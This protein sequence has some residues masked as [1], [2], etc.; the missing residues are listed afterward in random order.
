LSLSGLVNEACDEDFDPVLTPAQTYQKLLRN[1]TEKIRFSDM[2]GRIAAVMLVPYPPGIP[3]SM[4]GERLGGPDS[5]VIKLILAME[6]FS[7]RFPG[8][9]REVHGIEVDA[10]GNYWMRS[11][12]EAQ[13]KRRNGNGKNRPPS[14]A[15]PVKKRRRATVPPLT[16]PPHGTN[17]ER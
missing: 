7:K 3:M 12:I 2:A 14:S 17:T 1:E 10:E 15:P 4:P 16:E 6:E 9:E 5:P 11:V 8:F 13:G